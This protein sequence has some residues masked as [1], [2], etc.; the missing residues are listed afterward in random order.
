MIKENNPTRSIP[1]LLLLLATSAPV[2]AAS[3]EDFATWT[4][5]EDPPHA[6]MSATRL[7]PGGVLLNASGAIPAGTDI[8]YQSI[9]AADVS[10]STTGNYFSVD[11]DFHIAVDYSLTA[12]GVS[13]FTAIGFGIGEDGAGRNSAGALLAISNGVP[14]GVS[15]AA[16]VDDAT[17][18]PLPVSFTA[19]PSGRLFL[20][21]ESLSGD[22]TVG[23]S[24]TQGSLSPSQSATFGALQKDWNN[25]G[26]LVSLFLRSDDPSIFL[27]MSAGT[28]D[29]QFSSFQVLSG[30]SVAVVPLP[31]ALWLFLGALGAAHFFTGRKY[32][33]S[34]GTV[35]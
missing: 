23:V 18:A 32:A 17:L 35:H 25:A 28:L 21:Y 24:S 7:G 5:V 9:G 12:S 10:S 14:I 33:A 19:T 27:P 2:S 3:I 13:G 16:R 6:G 30:G 20:S 31:G 4:Q 34:P 11:D 15:G 22:I 29:A 8:G 26:L 1:A